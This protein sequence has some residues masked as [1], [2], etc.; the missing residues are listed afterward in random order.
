MEDYSNG[1]LK[2]FGDGFGATIVVT[3]T[4]ILP[5]SLDELRPAYY[6]LLYG[7]FENARSEYVTHSI[8]DLIASLWNEVSSPYLKIICAKKWKAALLEMHNNLLNIV[9]SHSDQC[10]R[11]C[12]PFMYY[13]EDPN[14]VLM[15]SEEA[16]ELLDTLIGKGPENLP[17]TLPIES[18]PCFQ[19]P[20]KTQFEY[21]TIFKKKEMQR[22][23]INGEDVRQ[24]ELGIDY[25][26]EQRFICPYVVEMEEDVKDYDLDY[27]KKTYLEFEHCVCYS[28]IIKQ[29]NGLDLF[30]SHSPQDSNKRK[31]GV[32]RFMLES[33][34]VRDKEQCRKLIHYALIP[35]K[36][37]SAKTDSNDTIYSYLHNDK[38]YSGSVDSIKEKLQ[39]YGIEIPQGLIDI[40]LRKQKKQ[41]T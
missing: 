24:V 13:D 32:L 8:Y 7:I 40:E 1:S 23:E 4:D 34:G 26:M 31:A 21:F 37:Y 9:N 33:F 27:Y 39:Y 38:Q 12:L 15:Y 30:D 14:G 18:I 11:V 28:D 25:E 3:D 36:P 35:D 22:A 10:V 20:I 29:K 5:I 16:I 2:G 6:Q 17:I 19:Y 41:S